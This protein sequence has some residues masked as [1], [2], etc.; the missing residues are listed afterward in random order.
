MTITSLGPATPSMP[1]VPTT[2]RLAS[3][4]QGLPGPTITATGAIVAVPKASAPTAAAPPA[5]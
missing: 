5:A 4:T 2:W 1:T 3:C